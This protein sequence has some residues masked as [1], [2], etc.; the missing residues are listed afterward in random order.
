[1]GKSLLMHYFSSSPSSQELFVRPFIP[2][3]QKYLVSSCPMPTLG[4]FCPDKRSNFSRADF[5]FPAALGCSLPAGGFP[6]SL[7]PQRFSASAPRGLQSVRRCVP[8][9]PGRHP[10]GALE[11]YAD[12]LGGRYAD[13]V[14]GRHA[15]EVGGPRRPGSLEL[16]WVGLRAGVCR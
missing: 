16:R 6:A 7:V 12:K 13:K 4:F 3:P 1:M 2:S 8:P 14:G 11:R 9:T 15:D 5:A 10:F